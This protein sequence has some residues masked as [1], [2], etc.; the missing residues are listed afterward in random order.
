M[1]RSA[2]RYDIATSVEGK[3]KFRNLRQLEDEIL[4]RAE[5]LA[6]IYPR[7]RATNEPSDTPGVYPGKGWR[8]PRFRPESRG[9]DYFKRGLL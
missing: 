5:P 8:Q 1:A 9:L 2:R 6:K 7:I 3:P 4:E